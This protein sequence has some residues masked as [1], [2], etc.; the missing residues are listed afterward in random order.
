MQHLLPATARYLHASGAWVLPIGLA[1]SEA[2]FPVND[3]R[4]RPARVTLR[5]GRPLRADDL[6]A[7][8]RGNRRVVMDAL[9][10]TLAAL[11]PPRYRGVYGTGF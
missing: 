7:A 3:A 10:L 11:L 5:A 9:G 2:L 1:G 8:A 6:F 4:L